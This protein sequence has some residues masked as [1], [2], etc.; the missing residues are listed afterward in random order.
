MNAIV[1][2]RNDL[3]SSLWVC[4]Q[5]MPSHTLVG[6][7]ATDTQAEQSN[8]NEI[9]GR[10]KDS[11][12][13]RVQSSSLCEGKR[14]SPHKV[15]CSGHGPAVSF[16]QGVLFGFWVFCM[17][18]GSVVAFSLKKKFSPWKE[19]YHA[20][21]LWPVRMKLPGDVCHAPCCDN[22]PGPKQGCCPPTGG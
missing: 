12:L 5:R 14:A 22:S 21:S 9:A 7:C 13:V 10:G 19:H 15:P 8:N 11:K 18:L 1:T 6:S 2:G 3:P 17:L 20:Q 16:P 4:Y